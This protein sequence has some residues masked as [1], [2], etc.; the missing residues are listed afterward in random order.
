MGSTTRKSLFLGALVAMKKGHMKN[1]CPLL[2]KEN[3]KGKGNG[4][5]ASDAKGKGKYRHSFKRGNLATW[6]ETDA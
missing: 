6:G 5:E 4:G 1:E 3:V 2:K